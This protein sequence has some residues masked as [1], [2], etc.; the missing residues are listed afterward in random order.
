M[1]DLRKLQLILLTNYIP[2]PGIVLDV[3]KISKLRPL[4][5]SYLNPKC[6]RGFGLRLQTYIVFRTKCE[7]TIVSIY[8]YLHVQFVTNL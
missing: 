3:N 4:T 2:V 6:K 8:I 7:H 1:S 5:Q